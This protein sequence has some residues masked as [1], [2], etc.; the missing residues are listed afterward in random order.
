[1]FVCIDQPLQPRRSEINPSLNF[2]LFSPRSLG[3]C[4]FS[5]LASPFFLLMVKSGEN[6]P[7]PLSFPFQ[8]P[9]IIVVG[10]LLWTVICWPGLWFLRHV[11][12]QRSRR[13]EMLHTVCKV[14][15]ELGKVE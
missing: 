13:H 14:R 4:A 1:M 11:D 8:P 15:V 6:K 3:T 5:R 7:L 9:G 12:G 2:P 10:C